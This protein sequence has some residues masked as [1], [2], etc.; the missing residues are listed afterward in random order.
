MEELAQ[1]TGILAKSVAVL[2]GCEEHSSLSRALS[3]L[4]EVEEKLDKVQE[5][6]ADDDFFIFAEFVKDYVGL[7]QSVKVCLYSFY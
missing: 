3:Q 6:Q 7:L 2:G 4:A 1:N 5:V